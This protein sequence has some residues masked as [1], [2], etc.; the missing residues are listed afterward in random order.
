MKA[1]LVLAILA[2]ATLIF[3]QYRRNRDT[4]KLL[5][6]LGSFVLIVSL[7]IAG[8]ITRMV[9]PVYIAHLV[10]LVAAWLGLLYYL[11]RNRYYWWLILSPLSTIGLFLLLELIE[12]SG[13]AYLG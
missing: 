1:L 2:T 4:R 5:I 3:L 9:F 12:G 10:L 7:G 13:H 8:N 11:M 6:A